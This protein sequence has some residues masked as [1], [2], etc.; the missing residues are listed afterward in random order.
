MAFNGFQEQQELFGQ[1]ENYPFKRV[2]ERATWLG[3]LTRYRQVWS[4]H[5]ARGALPEYFRI[6]KFLF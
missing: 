6:Q 3:F 1:H 2:R 5:T 4:I